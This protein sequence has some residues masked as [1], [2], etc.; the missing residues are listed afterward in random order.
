MTEEKLYLAVWNLGGE[1]KMTVPLDGLC[2]K[3][4]RVAYPLS[5]KTEFT[6]G[7]SS[8]TVEFT[9]EHQARIFEI[10]L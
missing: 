6:Y 3:S 7:P 4:A 1:K 9:E 8:L 10:A 5:L 2:V